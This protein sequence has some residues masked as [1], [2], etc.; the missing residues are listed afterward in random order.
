MKLADF[1]TAYANETFFGAD[2]GK[3]IAGFKEISKKKKK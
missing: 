1:G 2:V 3:K